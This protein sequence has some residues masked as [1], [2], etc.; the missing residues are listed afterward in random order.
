[1]DRNVLKTGMYVYL[2][3]DKNLRALVLAV[4]RNGVVVSYYDARGNSHTE[5]VSARYMT[6]TP[7][8]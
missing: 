3:G 6:L 7:E 8:D 2:Q 4:K 1:M 5:R